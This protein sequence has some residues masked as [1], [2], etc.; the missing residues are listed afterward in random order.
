MNQDS[1]IDVLVKVPLVADM[2]NM[3]GIK[4][5]KRLS[6]SAKLNKTAQ[7]WLNDLSKEKTRALQIKELQGLD[8]SNYKSILR[9]EDYLMLFES[10]EEEV[11]KGN[12]RK[13]FPTPKLV[14]E[15][16]HCLDVERANNV[17]LWK[18]ME[19]KEQGLNILADIWE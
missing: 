12:F 19:M 2:V 5:Y 7:R 16:A 17:L 18:H 1:D 11:R 9:A 6:N 14:K 15:L 3:I 4:P 10:D 13:V 8:G